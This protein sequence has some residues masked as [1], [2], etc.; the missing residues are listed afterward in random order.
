MFNRFTL[1]LVL[2]IAT[3][4]VYAQ[5]GCNSQSEC[6]IEIVPE[7]DKQ[8]MFSQLP[9]FLQQPLFSTLEKLPNPRDYK[10]DPALYELKIKGFCSLKMNESRQNIRNK[11]VDCSKLSEVETKANQDLKNKFWRHMGSAWISDF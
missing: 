4:L 6:F 10:N 9:K 1:G 5:T 8:A 7:L 11:G 3:S 2:L